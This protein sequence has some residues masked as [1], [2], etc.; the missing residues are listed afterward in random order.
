MNSGWSL[1][2][3]SLFSPSEQAVMDSGTDL[4]SRFGGIRPMFRAL[5]ERFGGLRS[6]S[7]VL[8]WKKNRR[9]PS[10]WQPRVLLLGNELGL[11]VTAEDV[12]FPF[13]EDRER[14]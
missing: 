10:D 5:R 2:V 9:V 12:M 7:T 11:D 6:P 1:G 8:G 14:V 4:F 3:D 13:P